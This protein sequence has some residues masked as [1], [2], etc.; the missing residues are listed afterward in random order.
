MVN[1]MI[2]GHSSFYL[3][4][5]WLKKGI[6]YLKKNNNENAFSKSNIE[7]IDE[8]GIGSVMVQSLKFWLELLDVVKKEN[9][10]YIF[11]RNIETILE[12]DPYLEN[13]NI[14]WLLHS[15]IL[16]REDKETEAT[17]WKFVFEERRNLSFTEE[18]LLNSFKVYLEKLG[19]K[20]SE[21]SLK[22]SVSV[23]IKTYNKGNKDILD[24]EE[25]IISP[26]LKLNYLKEEDGRYYFRNISEKEI[27]EYLVL[28]LLKREAEKLNMRELNIFDTYSSFNKIIKINMQDYEILINKLEK[29]NYISLER[30]AGLA[31]LHIVKIVS[32]EE[33][34]KRIIGRE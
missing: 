3:R 16:E 5:G 7:A 27:S 11:K 26:F 29:R 33:I 14:L 25:N 28:Y 20:M 9:K 1:N 31:T 8:L 21:R 23:F 4:V 17:L 22:D 24:P 32:N 10:K 19:I 30:V 13:N 2:V 15:Y 34:I 18:E 6:D 12:L